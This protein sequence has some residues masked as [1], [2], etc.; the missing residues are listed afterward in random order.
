MLTFCVDVMDWAHKGFAQCFSAAVGGVKGER[1]IL[2]YCP[3]PFLEDRGL[4][5]PQVRLSTNTAS[6]RDTQTIDTFHLCA[7]LKYSL[8]ELSFMLVPLSLIW[9]TLRSHL[10][11]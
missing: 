10:L 1:F 6:E 3:N 7:V 4:V 9:T 11:D 5:E 8:F 2:N